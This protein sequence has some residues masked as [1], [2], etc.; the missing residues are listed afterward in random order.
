MTEP[1]SIEGLYVHVPF[2]DGKCRYCA[3]Y[4]VPYHSAIS[5]AWLETLKREW[6]WHCR[7]FDL[8][9]LSTLFLG[10]G[11]PTMLPASQLQSLLEML[12]KRQG[13]GFASSSIEWTCEANPGSLTAENL[14][15]MKAAGVN[16]IS[17]GVQSMDDEVL[18]DLGRRHTVRDIRKAV[19]DLVSAG[20]T[21][22]SLDLIACVPGVSLATWRETLKAALEL[23]PAHVSVYA[24]TSE[25]GSRL[26]RELAEKRL[27]LLDD[28]VQLRMLDEAAGVLA[29]GG[30]QQYEISN[31]ARP[32]CECRHNVSCWRGGNYLGLGCAAASRVG[33]RRWTNKPDLDAYISSPCPPPR[34][35]EVLSS[36]TDATERLIFGLRMNEGIDLDAILGVTG[37]V[38]SS[39][40]FVWRRALDRLAGE[41]LLEAIPPRWRLTRRGQ[42]LADH[43]AVELM[44]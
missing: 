41:G 20:F 15:L 36:L 34:V 42:S 32:G 2:C 35:E 28:E 44:P 12:S 31:Y 38:D 17:L 13:A 21:N 27:T 8:I 19:A 9:R 24:L 40:A 33:R 11:T 1:A 4:S 3:F 23:G 7:E 6:E 16:R 39:Q 26:A 10:G 25:E 14:A 37:L 22:W 5:A 29:S 43:V 18:R 30:L